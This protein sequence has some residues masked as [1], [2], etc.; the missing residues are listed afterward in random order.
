MNDTTTLE[1]DLLYEVRDGIGRI[2][3]NRPQARNALT[4]NMYRRLAEICTSAGSDRSLKVLILTGAVG[5]CYGTLRYRRAAAAIASNQEW[6]AARPAQR[7]RRRRP[8]HADQVD[9]RKTA[10]ARRRRQFYL[11]PWPGLK[12]RA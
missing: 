6:R 3:F 10:A 4:F 11:R 7:F 2:T 9:H 5:V 8:C 1:S 12:H